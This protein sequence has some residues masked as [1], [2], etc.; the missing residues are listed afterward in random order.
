MP[1]YLYNSH[2]DSNPYTISILPRSIISYTLTNGN[3][4]LMDVSEIFSC[5][6]KLYNL[7]SLLAI[8]NVSCA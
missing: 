1:T 3:S 6:P 5:S 8:I 7:R 2:S 4:E